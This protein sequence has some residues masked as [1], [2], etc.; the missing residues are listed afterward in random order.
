MPKFKITPIAIADPAD[1]PIVL[2]ADRA[3]RSDS[4]YVNFYKGENLVAS[5]VNINFYALPE[6]VA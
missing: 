4:G 1:E 6:D 2:E 5:M 3:E